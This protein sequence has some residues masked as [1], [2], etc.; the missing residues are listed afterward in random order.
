MAN[1][2]DEVGDI[3]VIPVTGAGVLAGGLVCWS[4]AT[5]GVPTGRG[6]TSPSAPKKE[7]LESGKNLTQFGHP[8]KSPCRASLRSD[9]CPTI[10]DQCPI[11]LGMGVRIHRNAQFMSE[12]NKIIRKHIL[13]VDD[14]PEVRNTVKLLLQL[15]DH[16]VTEAK[17]GREALE[18]F[19]QDCFDLVISDYMM[20]EMRGDELAA[21]IKRLAPSQPILMLTGSFEMVEGCSPQ[22]DAV[23]RKPFSIGD[24]RAAI[25]R[26]C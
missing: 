2:G 14:E 22:M 10:P 4:K 3:V 7:A 8:F 23:L 19:T 11:I 18:M 6:D 17:N 20:P 16:T 15:D 24:L 21:N 12:P 9:N 1:V 5:T 26:L 25:A 13:L